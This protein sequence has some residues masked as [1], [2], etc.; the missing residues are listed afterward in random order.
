MI[1]KFLNGL[2][3][4]QFAHFFYFRSEYWG[5]LNF[6]MHLL[7][8]YIFCKDAV[9]CSLSP[10]TCSVMK[11]FDTFKDFQLSSHNQE[12][13]EDKNSP[14]IYTVGIKIYLETLSMSYTNNN[15]LIKEFI[16]SFTYYF[17]LFQSL[18]LD[19]F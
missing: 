7:W 6:P 13:D 10:S 3:V 18:Q 12:N 4:V 15:F 16:S 1:N 8:F 11:V 9:G 5:L 19:L 17:F 14:D 2:R